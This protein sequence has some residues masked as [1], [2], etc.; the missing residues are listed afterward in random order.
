MDRRKFIA[1]VSIATAIGMAGC[2]GD[3]GDGGEETSPAD[4]EETP[5]DGGETPTDGDGGQQNLVE[6]RTEGSEYIFDP[7][8]LFVESGTT[9]TFENVS[10]SHSS[11]AYV[12]GVG[13][14]TTT[15]IPEDAE[16]WNSETLA[17]GGATFDHT[18]DVA[19]TYDYFCI[20]HKTLGMVGRIVVDEP[21]GP[22]EGSMPPDG[23]V[24]E[25]SAIVEQ[26]SIG[27][28]EFHSG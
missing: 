15:L 25:S 19:G 27:W 12:D 10:G 17:E 24:P 5:A 21:G 13:G 9:I 16:G 20:P 18:F 14:A 2:G 26:G 11:T 4:G 28:D 8:G 1:N 23:D 22:A 3:G 7:V 6:M